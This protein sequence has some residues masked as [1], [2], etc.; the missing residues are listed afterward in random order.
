M[1]RYE[2]LPIYREAMNFL[3]FCEN[4]VRHFSRYNK[5][6]H[7]TD[8]RNLARTAVRL[9]I[10]ANNTPQKVPVLEELRITVEEIKVVLR[11]LKEVRAFQ[12]FNSFETAVN[13]AANIGRQ[14]EG[15]LRSARERSKTA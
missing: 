7:G 3:L 6:T 15:W 8:L 10:R 5:Y 1:A 14:A 11:V 13:H 12:N 9:I 2:H 4:A